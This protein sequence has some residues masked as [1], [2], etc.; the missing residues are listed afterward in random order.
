MSHAHL[1]YSFTFHT[2][3]LYTL[4]KYSAST[5]YTV[6]TTHMCT[7]FMQLHICMR[8]S[9][10]KS[11]EN[12]SNEENHHPVVERIFRFHFSGK[13]FRQVNWHWCV[14]THVNLRSKINMYARWEMFNEIFGCTNRVNPTIYHRFHREVMPWLEVKYCMKKNTIGIFKIHWEFAALLL[15]LPPPLCLYTVWQNDVKR[16]TITTTHT[17]LI[18]SAPVYFFPF[19]VRHRNKYYF[20]F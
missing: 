2:I 8:K 9:R 19:S 6:H 20:W 7:S 3:C 18:K 1:K 13:C 15:S 14:N 16:T 17:I 11:E 10:G 12:V 5:T 4:C